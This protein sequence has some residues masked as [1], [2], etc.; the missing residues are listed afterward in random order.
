MVHVKAT[1][2]YKDVRSRCQHGDR[3][4]N[5]EK[6][7]DNQTQPIQDHC[8]KFPVTLNRRRLFVIPNFVCD[9][10]YFLENEAEFPVQGM[11]GTRIRVFVG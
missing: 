3:R 6:G 9:H 11:H 1:I 7:V 4:Y 10:F 5:C 2:L 8:S